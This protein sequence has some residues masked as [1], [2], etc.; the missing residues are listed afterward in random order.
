MQH[1]KTQT[2]SKT[3]SE[4]QTN[5]IACSTATNHIPRTS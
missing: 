1:V 2:R 5:A 4:E 3:T